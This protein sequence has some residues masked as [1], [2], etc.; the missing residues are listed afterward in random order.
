MPVLI[1]A[2]KGKGGG[3]IGGGAPPPPP[4]E[5]PELVGIGALG[6]F[7]VGELGGDIGGP[8]GFKPS[9]IGIDFKKPI[10][11]LI[12]LRKP[13]PLGSSALTGSPSQ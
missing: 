11:S 1:P 9:A 13:C 5:V 3:S 4:M 8:Q 7:I 2:G 12:I 10:P 6:P